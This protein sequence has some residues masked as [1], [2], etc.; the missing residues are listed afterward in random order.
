MRFDGFPDIQRLWDEYD[1]ACKDGVLRGA[2]RVKGMEV[3]AGQV[4]RAAN[5]VISQLEDRKVVIDKMVESMEHQLEQGEKVKRLYGMLQNG[6]PAK[7]EPKALPAANPRLLEP[8]PPPIMTYVSSQ[9]IEEEARRFAMHYPGNGDQGRAFLQ[10]KA[11][12]FESQGYPDEACKKIIKRA[13]EL[14]ER[15]GG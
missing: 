7:E 5:A 10:N 8:A 13:I 9:K 3:K 6:I 15:S 14:Y 12:Y 4:K 2:V 1:G 11:E